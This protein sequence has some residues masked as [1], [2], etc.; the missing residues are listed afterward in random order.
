MQKGRLIVVAAAIVMALGNRMALAGDA[1]DFGFKLSFG[2]SGYPS[3]QNISGVTH[4]VMGDDPASFDARS[5]MLY[6]FDRKFGRTIYGALCYA[7]T[8][9]LEFEM[10]FGYTDLQLEITQNNR[11]GAWNRLPT[12]PEYE[13]SLR[14]FDTM[15]DND[16]SIMTIRPAARFTL[17]M[18]SGIIPYICAGIDIMSVK[19]SATLDYL[20]PYVTA[21]VPYDELNTTTGEVGIEGREMVLGLDLGSGLEYRI[22]PAISMTFGATY[23]FQFNKAFKDFDELIKDSGDDSNLEHTTYYSDGMNVTNIS[24]ALGMSVRL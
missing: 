1:S 19:A 18:T 6:H 3:D 2:I 11:L 16:F 24:F 21:G 10:G 4:P 12:I 23:L 20:S 14:S 13:W 17:S 7:A 22:T 9:H 15:K 5:V 8:S